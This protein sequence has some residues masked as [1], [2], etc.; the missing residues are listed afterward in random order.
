MRRNRP[1]AVL[2]LAILNVIFAIFWLLVSIYSAFSLVL[3]SY[4]DSEIGAG[5]G[6]NPVTAITHVPGYYL[7]QISV[8]VFD[9]LFSI[10]L[11]VSG[12][13]LFSKWTNFNDSV[14][15]V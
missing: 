11:L 6:G 2:V 12:I 4:M 9:F 15:I 8:V 5:A 3:L 14:N 10:L 1:A 13:G 7:F